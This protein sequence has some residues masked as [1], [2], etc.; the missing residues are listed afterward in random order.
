MNQLV[1]PLREFLVTLRD[2]MLSGSPRD[3]FREMRLEGFSIETLNTD[4]LIHPADKRWCLV[5]A[6]PCWASE[7]KLHILMDVTVIDAFLESS[8]P[9]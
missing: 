9:N 3:R 6:A 1:S 8:L 2:D 4:Q 5:T 7:L